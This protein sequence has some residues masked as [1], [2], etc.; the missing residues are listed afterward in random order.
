MV[1][2]ADT[3]S[4]PRQNMEAFIKSKS[5]ADGRGD[6][7]G[8]KENLDGLKK[9]ASAFEGIFINML[10][11]AMRK[12]VDTDGGIFPASSTEKMFQDM[13]DE[14]LSNNM[15]KNKSLG[16]ADAVI[17]TYQNRFNKTA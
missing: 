7:M 9:T 15:A 6:L 17:K 3:V 10:F 1:T 8:L 14:E 11:S 13:L 12:T 16:I 5:D 2:M 4:I